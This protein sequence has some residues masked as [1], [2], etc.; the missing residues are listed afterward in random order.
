MNR[1]STSAS[2]NKV[3]TKQTITG[4]NV[5]RRDG[6][7]RRGRLQRA[8]HENAEKTAAQFQFRV[9]PATRRRGARQAARDDT[10]ARAV[11]AQV[12]FGDLWRRRLDARW[13][14]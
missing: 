10:G 8:D 6:D 13:H 3:R 1:R 2:R 5:G 7:N 14:L 11:E 12:L 9:F 4:T